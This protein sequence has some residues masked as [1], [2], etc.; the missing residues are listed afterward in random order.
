MSAT[1]LAALGVIAALVGCGPTAE[2][3]A[4]LDAVQRAKDQ[5]KCAGFGFAP[6]TDAFAR[7]MMGVSSQRDAEAAADRRAAAARAAA[8]DRAR[9]AAQAAKD[10]ADR[11]AWDRRTGQG[12]YFNTSTAQPSDA[13]PSPTDAVRDAI[14]RD[15]RQ[16]EGSE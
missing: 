7:C 5:D 13:S 6:G 1:R 8:D 2:E 10:R 4:A 11:D 16:I 14:E 3:Q 15:Q 12:K 9:D